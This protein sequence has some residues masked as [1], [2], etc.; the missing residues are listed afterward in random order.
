MRKG[1]RGLGGG[2]WRD[3]LCTSICTCNHVHVYV[4]E[5]VHIPY[6]QVSLALLRTINGRIK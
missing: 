5:H 6:K 4:H 2:R 1:G 3:H